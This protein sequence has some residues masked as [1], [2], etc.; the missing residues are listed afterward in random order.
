MDEKEKALRDAADAALAQCNRIAVF[1]QETGEEAV[2]PYKDDICEH[3]PEWYFMGTEP[4][5]DEFY[6]A[7][8]E[9]LYNLDH[10]LTT[11]DMTDD[12]YEKYLNALDLE[13]LDSEDIY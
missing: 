5:R 1:R 4:V 3:Y 8:L 6:Y 11:K 7:Y 12:E 9:A 13:W 2:V 10:Y